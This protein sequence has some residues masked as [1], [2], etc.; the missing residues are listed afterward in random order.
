MIRHIVLLDFVKE[1]EGVTAIE[2]AVKA[3]DLA[4]ELVNK[5]DVLKNIEVGVNEAD[6]DS[7]NYTFSLVCDFDSL[8]DLQIYQ[9]HPEHLKLSSFFSKITIGRVCVDYEID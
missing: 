1:F 2:N 6:A 8:E 9:Q 5:I 3:R 4:K 7:T